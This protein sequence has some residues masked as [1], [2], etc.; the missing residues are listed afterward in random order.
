MQ[1]YQARLLFTSAPNSENDVPYD[2]Q[3]LVFP[4]WPQF[5]TSERDGLLAVLEQPGWWRQAGSHVADFERA[6]ANR[7]GAKYCLAVSSGTAALEIALA[8]IGVKQ[9]D[10]VIVPA[11]TF[12]SCSL[13]V[14]RVGAV[15]VP[16]DVA[17]D[18]YCLDVDA[19]AAA[20]GPRTKVIMAVHMAGQFADV[21][22][23][24][25]LAKS[26]G[27]ELLHDAAHAHGARWR[28]HHAGELG[29]IA[30]FSFQNGKLM[31]AG[32][33]GAILFPDRERFEDAYLRHSCGRPATD[34]HYEHRTQGSNQR[35]SEFTAS[36]LSAQLTRLDEHLPLRERGAE[37]L[38]QALST[39]KG[40]LAARRDE[41]CD[42]HSHYM[43][44]FRVP[45][46]ND[47]KTLVEKLNDRGVPA[48][49]GFPP[50][51]RTEGWSLG[52]TRGESIER[53]AAR[54]PNTE[55]IGREC[56]WLHH[57]ILLAEPDTI[58]AVARQVSEVVAE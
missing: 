57:R 32:E 44:M 50:I 26:A 6:F 52:P 22:A 15:P 23:L 33:G 58:R 36:V 9:G 29:G 31:T 8:S 19:T 5:G 37:I 30:T 41:R 34:K 46:I 53:E 2:S 56:V 55:I 3:E 54:C 10:E 35:M 49:V 12:I 40:V 48:F 43:A 7:H 24:G 20:I 39:V 27:V 28:G 47:R 17:L 25:A 4:S 13:A 16:V 18:T 21:D 42:L 38:E 45:G 14:Q 1:Q 51:Y 11:F